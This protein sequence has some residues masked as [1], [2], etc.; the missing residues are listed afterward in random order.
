MT[1]ES[2]RPGMGINIRNDRNVR[3]ADLIVDGVKKYETRRGKSLRPYVG[4]RVQVVRTGEGP[5]KAIGEVTVGH[6]QVVDHEQF[7]KM[8]HLHHVPEGSKWDCPPGE[9]RTLYPMHDPVRYEGEHAPEGL[10]IVARKT[11]KSLVF[12]LR[13][14]LVSPFPDP[15]EVFMKASPGRMVWPKT[16]DSGL[17]LERKPTRGM[18]FT[19]TRGVRLP[20]A[21]GVY[22]DGSGNGWVVKSANYDGARVEHVADRLASIFGNE[23]NGLLPLPSKLYSGT[24]ARRVGDGYKWKP[25]E[26]SYRVTP[27]LSGT[28]VG[29]QLDD[30]V[31][32]AS[33]KRLGHSLMFHAL[34][35]HTDNQPLNF[36]DPHGHRAGSDPVFHGG[37]PGVHMLDPG[38]SLGY[39]PLGNRAQYDTWNDRD[40]FKDASLMPHLHGWTP[41]RG[42]FYGSRSVGAGLRGTDLIAQAR[43]LIDTYDRRRDEVHDAFGHMPNADVHRAVLDRRINAFRKMVDRYGSSPSGGARL[44]ERLA[45]LE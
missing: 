42:S 34:I 18:N 44:E 9:Q 12:P 17:T 27:L 33:L 10:G 29:K 4:R 15:E 1:T 37:H 23:R 16:L 3:Y 7:G 14:E 38:G 30:N 20:V 13:L 26:G 6:P 24:T 28:E 11:R 19:G 45:R 5:A 36:W 41:E 25:H 22:R 21:S 31:R 8:R 32:L 39:G 40:A 2:G 35:D 43:D